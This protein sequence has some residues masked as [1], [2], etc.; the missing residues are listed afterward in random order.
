MHPVATT[1]F[2]LLWSTVGQLGFTIVI[3]KLVRLLIVVKSCYVLKKSVFLSVPLHW[4]CVDVTIFG[5][6]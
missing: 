6:H 2:W 4:T 5:Q 1:L 3:R